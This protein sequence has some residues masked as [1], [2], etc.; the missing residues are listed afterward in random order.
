MEPNVVEIA[1]HHVVA[2]RTLTP[3]KAEA[4]EVIDVEQYDMQNGGVVNGSSNVDNKNKGK[5]IESDSLSYDEQD[6]AYDYDAGSPSDACDYP[7]SSPVSNSLLDPDSLIYEDDYD[8]D[9]Q[10]T[11]EMDE[12]PDTYSMYQDLFDGKD[13]PT[14][15]EVSMDWFP[16]SADQESANSSGTSK[17]DVAGSS[18][19]KATTTGGGIQSNGVVPNS[20]YAL[21][22]ITKAPTSKTYF[23]TTYQPQPHPVPVD[24]SGFKPVDTSG[25]KPVDTPG[26]KGGF[27]GF[28][29]R[30]RLDEPVAPPDSS[31]VKR[32][33]EDFLGL[34][35]FFKRF[36]VVEDFSDHHYVTM[37]TTSKQHSKEWARRIQDEWRILGSDLPEMIFVR[38]YESRMDLLRAVIIGA[39]GTPYHDGLYFF[40]I[41]FPDTYPNTPPIVHYH[42]GGL[43]INPNLYNCGK[44]CLSLLG[45]WQGSPRE[46]WIPNTS[47]MLQV[48]VSIQGLILNQKPY[49]NEPGYERNAGSPSGEKASESYSE[50]TFILCLKTMVYTMRRPPKYFEDFV[51]GHFFSCAHDFL[52]AC[53]AYR[54]GA[55]PGT[56]L[57][58]GAQGVEETSASSSQK[59]RNDV[60]TFVE[61]VLLKEF[62][63]LG[64][65]GLEKE[66]EEKAPETNVAESSNSTR[67]S[68]KRN[69]VSSS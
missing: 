32:N 42:S 4:P 10:Y 26:F 15:V 40:D 36:D 12:E 55:P 30:Q 9:D 27:K 69:K 45:T 37:G 33:M 1:S 6:D 5:A 28:A 31:R 62:I 56:T 20:A 43:R 14:G 2:S 25:F 52:K 8:Y 34:Y 39:Q 16:N 58:K 13:V 60:A 49:F 47:T 50:N 35:L 17:S 44:V 63:L 7:G 66:E 53:N 46:K 59:F 61:T 67:S 24:T 29:G 41:F 23:S 21:P 38:A 19:K 51:Y 48:L 54:N 11:Y 68:S 57:V 64:V 65:L 22:Q 18:S 3:T